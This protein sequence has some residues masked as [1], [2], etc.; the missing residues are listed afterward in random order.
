MN[1]MREALEAIAKRA[2]E[3]Q[4]QIQFDR[5]EEFLF[6]QLQKM[7]EQALASEPE[8]AGEPVA[9]HNLKDVRCACCGYMTYHREHMGCIRAAHTQHAQKMVRPPNCGTGFCSCIECPYGNDKPAGEPV[10]YV[11]LHKPSEYVPASEWE[12]IDPTCH[13][14]YGPVYTHPNPEAVRKLVDAAELVVN[15]FDALPQMSPARPERLNINAIRAA[16]AEVRA[17]GGK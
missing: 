14:L 3:I 11:N 9:E 8:P 5:G 15:T 12:N 7:A 1:K 13:C 2:A 10:G 16:L 17:M 4:D 6:E